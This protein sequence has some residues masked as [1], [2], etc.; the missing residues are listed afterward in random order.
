M[1]QDAEHLRRLTQYLTGHGYRVTA[2]QGAD[3]LPVRLQLE[4]PDLILLEQRLGDVTG[5]EVL[6]R[7]RAV[8]SV[9]VIILTAQ[10]DPVD[11]I[12]NLEMGADDQVHKSVPEREI[13]ARM[14]AVLRRMQGSAYRSQPAWVLSEGRR[15]VVR[16]DGSACGLTTAEFGVLRALASAEGQAVT[17]AE[18]CERVLGRP[19]HPGDRAVDTVICKLRQKLAPG[20]IVTVRPAGYAFAG[21]PSPAAG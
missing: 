15:D 2:I 16:P 10:S 12:I 20:V 4:S 18:L 7:I 17:R 5:T 19:L 14:R 13:M 1:D 6:G 9:P 8:S 21:F 11:R 3:E